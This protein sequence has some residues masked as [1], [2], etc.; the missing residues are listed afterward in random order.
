MPHYDVHDG[1]RRLQ[2]CDRGGENIPNF[3]SAKATIRAYYG[4]TDGIA[5]KHKSRYITEMKKLRDKWSQRLKT[6]CANQAARGNRPAVVFD[7]DDTTL[8]TY[9][10]EDAAM[11]FNFDPA[12]QDEWV[13]DARFPA[14]PGMKR[15]VKAAQKP[16]LQGRSGSP[17][18]A[19]TRRRRTLKNLRKFY[20]DAFAEQALLHQV[21][22]RRAA[23]VRHLRGEGRV[24]ARGVQVADPQARREAV[25]GE[26]H[27]ATSVTSSPTCSAGTASPSSCRTRR[28]TCR[29]RRARRGAA[30]VS[31]FL[32][33][34]HR[35]GTVP[36]VAAT[37][38]DLLEALRS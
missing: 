6:R 4:A 8:W 7:A 19:P 16:R 14:V 27:R 12:L 9:D 5:A 31:Y 38:A 1:A 20:G 29:S 17:A 11:N 35:G 37:A 23:V 3:D 36:V 34:D 2:R 10:M 26:D 25:R 28:T 15:V 22:R 18:A 33:Q 32:P 30:A 13:Q 21:G 24:H